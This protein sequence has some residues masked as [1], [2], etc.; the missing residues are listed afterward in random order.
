MNDI[1]IM[2]KVISYIEDLIEKNIIE[3]KERSSFLVFNHPE[4]KKRFTGSK[5]DEK[6]RDYVIRQTLPEMEHLLNDCKYLS[7]RQPR[8]KTG[9]FSFKITNEKDFTCDLKPFYMQSS[10]KKVLSQ[11][12]E[13]FHLFTWYI[14]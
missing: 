8:T 5:S 13:I 6:I 12:M 2:T 3:Y 14:E 1:V 10:K 11:I 4:L 7:I 9:H